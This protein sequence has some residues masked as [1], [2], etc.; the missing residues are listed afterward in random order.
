VLKWINEGH[1]KAFKTPG[2]HHRIPHDELMSFLKRYK[3]PIPEELKPHQKLLVIV[4][5]DAETQDLL[6]Q[7]IESV[8][9]D[10]KVVTLDN[11]IDALFTI[12]LQ[13]PELVILDVD[14]PNVDGALLCQ[15]FR[16]YSN[17]KNIRLLAIS[18]EHSKIV[19]TF[20]DAF[21]AKPLRDV[22]K[23]QGKIRRLVG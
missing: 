17:T 7:A 20:A 22:K 13:R 18:S 15:K 2:G 16:S 5:N 4:S 14:L 3:M 21:L 8:V 12:T 19:E 11:S 23:L 9:P 10:A 1:I 6:E